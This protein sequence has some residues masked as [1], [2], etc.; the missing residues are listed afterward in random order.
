MR[1]TAAGPEASF[2]AK[3]ADETDALVFAAAGTKTIDVPAGYKVAGFS[4]TVD[5]WVRQGPALTIPT[6]D[7]IDGSAPTLNPANRWLGGATK[8]TVGVSVPGIVCI[9][10][11]P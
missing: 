9:A 5:F 2:T 4:S 10:W 11:Y 3:F 7:V 8:L 6:A 1:A